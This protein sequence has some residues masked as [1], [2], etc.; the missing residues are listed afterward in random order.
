MI[1][2]K[3]PITIATNRMIKIGN[4]AKM[5]GV[6]P[7]RSRHGRDS[8]RGSIKA[9]S[10]GSNGGSYGFSLALSGLPGMAAL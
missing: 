7:G 5:L 4:A 2:S 1:G 6:P 10:V 8:L 9:S 3:S